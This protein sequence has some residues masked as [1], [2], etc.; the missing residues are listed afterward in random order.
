M[1]K[2]TGFFPSCNGRTKDAYYCWTPETPPKA[3]LQLSHGMC[4]YVERY[5]PLAEYLCSHG[6]AF[7]GHDHPGHGHSA[8][9]PEELGFIDENNGAALLVADLK[10]MNL[11]LQK[12]FPDIPIFLL[13]HSMGSFVARL[14][15][16]YY[17]AGLCGAVICGTSGGNPGAK[18]GILTANEIIRRKGSRCRSE[19]L[20]KMAFGS[21]N[22]TFIG[23]SPY[24]WLSA[25][26]E[27]VARYEKD[28]FCNFTFTAAGFRDLFTLLTRVSAPEWA[29]S[30][31]KELPLLLIA[32]GR[33]PVGDYGKGVRKVAERLIGAG[34][35]DVS[36]H[37]YPEGRH[38][39]FN[40][41]NR[42]EVF[43]DLLSWLESR[44]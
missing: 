25:D 35:N 10:R 12:N 22:R 8:P 2:L 26:R 4:E 28:P 43:D 7:A 31:P 40:E 15:L 32:G 42:Q 23:S 20:N 36:L 17:A 29:G 21:Y 14:Y 41:L 13:G 11:L 3:V 18:A 19:L 1:Q 39:I 6:I 34:L 37:I 5:E 44:L 30:L 27:I 38:E 16:S 9:S 24:E 33:D